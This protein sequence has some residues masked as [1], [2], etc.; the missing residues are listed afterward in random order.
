MTDEK[1][2]ELWKEYKLR[3]SEKATQEA[4]QRAVSDLI[5]TV[6]KKTLGL[7]Q[8]TQ[9]GVIHVRHAQEQ[10]KQG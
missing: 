5:Q 10:V 1:L 7:Y 6:A 3:A 4:Q 8:I 2:L 9:K